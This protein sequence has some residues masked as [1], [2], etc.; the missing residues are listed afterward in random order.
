MTQTL[1][2]QYEINEMLGSG[3]LGPVHDVTDHNEGEVIALRLVSDHLSGQSFLVIQL[4]RLLFKV[5]SL[6]HPHIL[7]TEPLQQ[8][9]H[10]V[11]YGMACAK[12]GSVRQLLNEL[13]VGQQFP[14]ALAVSLAHQAAK[15]LV[16]A[17]QHDLMHGN[18][19][20]EN[21][22]LQPGPSFVDHERYVVMLSDFGLNDLRYGQPEALERISDKDI[23]YQSPEQKEEIR[24]DPRSDI[25]ALGLVLHEMLFG[26]L[27]SILPLRA[28]MLTKARSEIT[29]ELEHVIITCLEQ[30]PKNRY[31]NAENLEIALDQALKQLTSE[32]FNARALESFQWDGI[33]LD[34]KK[35][36]ETEEEQQR[37]GSHLMPPMMAPE[38]GID[39]HVISDGYGIEALE[40]DEHA[41]RGEVEDLT[42]LQPT[43]VEEI[44][45]LELGAAKSSQA[46]QIQSSQA[47]SQ[48]QQ[49]DE[50]IQPNRDDSVGIAATPVLGSADSV[51]V[52]DSDWVQPDQVKE[53]GEIEPAV[54]E[55]GA[56]IFLS[57]TEAD[58][59]S[60]YTAG[61]QPPEVKVKNWGTVPH[62][63]I[64]DE[65]HELVRAQMIEGSSFT[66][67]RAVGNTVMLDS[68]RIEAE[69]LKI[70][71]RDA[72]PFVTPL[73]TAESVLLDDR[74]LP[75]GDATAWPFHKPLY[76]KPYWLVLLAPEKGSSALSWTTESTS[77]KTRVLPWYA[78]V[79]ALGVVTL[80]GSVFWLG[81]PPEIQSFE[82][83]D[84]GK[85]VRPEESLQSVKPK[86]S[87]QLAWNIKNASNVRI[88]ELNQQGIELPLQGKTTVGGI[89]EKKKYTLVARSWLGRTSERALEI[90]PKANTPVIKLFKVEPRQVSGEQKVKIT[91]R[92][93]DANKVRI[94]GHREDSREKILPASETQFS[95]TPT[96]DTTLKFIAANDVLETEKKAEVTILQPEIEELV[97]TP[98]MVERGQKA[99]IT[100]KVKHAVKVN[101][102][103]IGSVSNEGSKVIQPTEDTTYKMVAQNVS[104]VSDQ[105][106]LEVTVKEPKPEI[107]AVRVGPQNPRPGQRMVVSWKTKGVP[108]VEL[109]LGDKQWKVPANG[110]KV[111]IAPRTS[112]SLVLKAENADG[113]IQSRKVW[114][115]VAQAQK[116]EDKTAAKDSSTIQ[117]QSFVIK[118]VSSAQDKVTLAWKVKNASSIRLDGL[119]GP[120]ANGSWPAQGL[121]TVPVKGQRTFVLRV[122]TIGLSRTVTYRP[123]VAQ[124]KPKVIIPVIQSFRV[125]PENPVKGTFVTLSWKVSNAKRVYINGLEG[126]GPDG[127][128]PKQGTTK[129]K[130]VGRQTFILNAQ[131]DGRKVSAQRI[132]VAIGAQDARESSQNISF[133]ASSQTVRSGEPVK[134]RWRTNASGRVRI[135]GLAGDFPAQGMISVKPSQ[136]T[137]YTLVAGQNRQSVTI[138]VEKG[139]NRDL[140][141]KQMLG[142]WQH[143]HGTLNITDIQGNRGTGLLFNSKLAAQKVPVKL[144][145]NRQNVTMRSTDGSRFS[146]LAQIND[147]GNVLRGF[148][149]VNDMRHNWC[150]YRSIVMP[151]E[152]K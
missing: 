76:V 87:F 51:N 103:G 18:L 109:E 83:V 55:E 140:N 33:E 144:I 88:V 135:E 93:R 31:S 70:D 121:T 115:K 61:L 116:K 24:N 42:S 132:A 142:T 107:L 48:A 15:G 47:H 148:Y 80:A 124:S 110:Q 89:T 41:F 29:P 85:S 12:R 128:W 23:L 125:V 95:F 50:V 45:T 52:V 73:D 19:K 112:T 143:L 78:V 64:L 72:Q 40:N 37:S 53:H 21:L 27:P 1:F 84:G 126:P 82:L 111:L 36:K 98:S 105:Q 68:D 91:W 137:T 79:G 114:V 7:P 130:V 59:Y 20:P 34:P 30:N 150:A 4:K 81:R 43:Q 97:V 54:L 49:K 96:R 113:I 11:F 108:E 104:E 2:H 123:S 25:Y 58:T 69:H 46:K 133:T 131:T 134:L 145:F 62:L 151:D 63:R 28:G 71:F 38:P 127:S 67:G 6:Q 16:Y 86:E 129:V 118:E 22:L 141:Y 13:P 101:I 66:V 9:E 117:I 74:P 102:S 147:N 152:C 100:W 35:L 57:D 99:T 60:S 136:T 5:N 32:E 56:P 8:R 139:Q 39:Q 10:R 138:K 146:L 120:N 149:K 90:L 65:Y 106:S 94:S 75:S 17:H 119:R 92:T 77:K 122:G 3:W 44:E 14:V 26:E